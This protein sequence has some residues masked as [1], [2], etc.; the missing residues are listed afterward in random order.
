MFCRIASSMNSR[1]SF[2]CRGIL[3][4]LLELRS[5]FTIAGL[6]NWKRHSNKGILFEVVT[7]SDSCKPVLLL[8]QSDNKDKLANTKMLYHES[9]IR[10]SLLLK[11]CR[12]MNSCH[13]FQYRPRCISQYK[14][15]CFI[16]SSSK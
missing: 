5:Q 3:R 8:R 1:A 2:L 4:S 12:E 9:C 13:G 7:G 14:L 15:Y 11:D 6:D 16:L 10:S